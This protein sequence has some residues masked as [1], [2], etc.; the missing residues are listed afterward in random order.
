MKTMVEPTQKARILSRL[1][2]LPLFYWGVVSLIIGQFLYFSAILLSVFRLVISH[3]EHLVLA[4]RSLLWAS[5]A[6]ST[7]GLL[8]VVLDLALMFPR[9]RR[10][11]RRMLAPITRELSFTVA[12]TAYNDEASIYDAV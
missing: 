1:T 7:L 2:T 11:A 5:G 8:L 3:T 12:L 10:S 6:P 4:I 9:K